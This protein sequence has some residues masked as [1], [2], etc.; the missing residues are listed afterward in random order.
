M[1]IA[2]EEAKKCISLGEVPIG[3]A[4][5]DKN[6]S[7]I[8]RAGNRV[9][10]YQ[11]PTAHAEILAIRKA[12]ELTNSW[13][14]LDCNLYVTIEPCSMCSSAIEHSRLKRLYFGCE[15]FKSGSVRN[16]AKIFMNK[17]CHHIPEIYDG[18]YENECKELIK[19]FFLKIRQSNEKFK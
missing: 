9:E 12:S 2:I 4:L 14:L 3:A 13:R 16:G 10:T 5:T 8:S 1:K 18:F 15:D 11:D 7:I 17:N 6:G 19:E